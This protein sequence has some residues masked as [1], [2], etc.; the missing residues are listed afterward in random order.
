M[1]LETRRDVEKEML[2]FCT[3]ERERDENAYLL[4]TNVLVVGLF[5]GSL[6]HV[7][8]NI[9]VR[10]SLVAGVDRIEYL[11]TPKCYRIYK[12]KKEVYLKNQIDY[13]AEK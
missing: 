6:E 4:S 5:C 13:Y 8:C 3:L 9:K 11:N 10:S 12:Y 1:E 2:N 7:W